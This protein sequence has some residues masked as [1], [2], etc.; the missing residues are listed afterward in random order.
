VIWQPH[1][2]EKAQTSCYIYELDRG[3][4]YDPDY[5]FDKMHFTHKGNVQ[6]AELLA[7]FSLE[8]RLP[9]PVC[10]EAARS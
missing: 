10:D 7:Q 2:L 5:L 9:G 6:V 8:S 4:A 3:L 1:G